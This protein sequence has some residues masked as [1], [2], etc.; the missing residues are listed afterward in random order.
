MVG[1][2][3]PCRGRTGHQRWGYPPARHL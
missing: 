3:R 1:R 2:C